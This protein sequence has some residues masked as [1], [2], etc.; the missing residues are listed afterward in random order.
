MGVLPFRLKP[1]FSERPWGLRDL[2]PGM[3]IRGRRS[4]WVRPG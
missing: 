3:E 4:W 1:W 2:R